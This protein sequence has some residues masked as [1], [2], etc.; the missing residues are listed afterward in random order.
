MGIARDLV[1]QMMGHRLPD[2]S[3]D[4]LYLDRP[5]EKKA[6]LLIIQAMA[7]A[8]E[9]FPAIDLIE[10]RYRPQISKRA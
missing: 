3:A 4:R 2:K 7:M 10:V 9:V 8:E 5:L 6:E 1:C